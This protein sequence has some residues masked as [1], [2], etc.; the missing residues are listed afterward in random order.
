MRDIGAPNHAA[1]D[2]A[3]PWVGK[4]L[5]CEVAEGVM[6]IVLGYG[7][8][9]AVQVSSSQCVESSARTIGIR[10]RVCVLGMLDD[11]K[12]IIR[13]QAWFCRKG[14]RE[15]RRGPKRLSRR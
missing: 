1:E 10:R 15:S 2:R 6:H 4:H 7:G 5:L 3:Q 9:D 8:G 13:R 12:M 11:E 14:V